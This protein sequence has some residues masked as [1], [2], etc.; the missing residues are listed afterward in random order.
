MCSAC[1]SGLCSTM[2]HDHCSHK[3][4]LTA[5]KGSRADSQK[6]SL[7]NINKLMHLKKGNSCW[8]IR[9]PVFCL[10]NLIALCK[11]SQAPHREGVGKLRQP[12]PVYISIE[13]FRTI[14]EAHFCDI[15]TSYNVIKVSRKEMFEMFRQILYHLIPQMMP[16]CD[17][18]PTK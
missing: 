7:I 10:W 5:N 18:F 9:R 2:W 6:V 14:Y 8:N 1:Y 15:Q 17:L 12:Q 3:Q 4:M 16:G 13:P 11:Y